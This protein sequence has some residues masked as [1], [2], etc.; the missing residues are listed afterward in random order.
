MPWPVSAGRG[1]HDCDLRARD[2]TLRLQNP[3]APTLQAG[4]VAFSQTV[5]I[6]PHM[7]PSD[8]RLSPHL[9]A[10]EHLLSEV[11]RRFVT[12][13]NAVASIARASVA[14]CWRMRESTAA[15]SRTTSDPLR[16]SVTASKASTAGVGRA[17]STPPPARSPK[18]E[19]GFGG[20]RRAQR[21]GWRQPERPKVHDSTGSVYFYTGFS[22]S[23]L[24]SGS[25]AWTSMS[26]RNAKKNIVPGGLAP[27]AP[28]LS[29]V[30][31][32]GGCAC[33]PVKPA[34]F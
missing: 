30:N 32:D 12:R 19:H 29:V 24:A 4:S 26:D 31:A 23:Y 3:G 15:K 2:C 22:G 8:R 7:L 17:T 11:I 33:A 1:P 20:G 5:A 27:P 18:G 28:R 10:A 14:L 9:A 6:P 21:D 13:Q 16:T 34:A 25:G